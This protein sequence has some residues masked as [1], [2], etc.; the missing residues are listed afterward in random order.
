MYDKENFYVFDK[1]IIYFKK[2]NSLYER[3][4]KNFNNLKLK[5]NW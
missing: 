4:N 1:I 2:G 5:S 3:D